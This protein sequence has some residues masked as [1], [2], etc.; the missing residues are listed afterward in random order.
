M[1][2]HTTET[3]TYFCR[4][5]KKNRTHTLVRKG[6]MFSNQLTSGPKKCS[7]SF[8]FRALIEVQNN[9][10]ETTIGDLQGFAVVNLMWRQQPCIAIPLTA[11][12]A[13]WLLCFTDRQTENKSWS[14]KSR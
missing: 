2:E 6:H 10:S 1:S 3:E 8:Y 9:L 12:Q 11:L 7:I 14:A 13:L 4:E 5:R